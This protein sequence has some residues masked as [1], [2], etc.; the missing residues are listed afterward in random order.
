MSNDALK[1]EGYTVPKREWRK[2]WKALKQLVETPEDTTQVFIIM[3]AL[4]GDAFWKEF[5]RFKATEFGKHVLSEK[6]DLFDTLTNRD[7]LSSLPAGSFG[8]T[9]YDF[10]QREGIS[11]EGLVEASDGHYE[12][13]TSEDMLRYARRS[14]ESHD[15]WHILS[16]YG[17]DG[18][19][20]AC[21]VSFSYAQTKS[22]GF[23]AIAAMGAYKFK[24][25]FPDAPIWR[26]VW[27]AYRIGKK[28]AWLPGVEW[29]KLMDLPLEEVR[30][31]LGIT[32]PNLYQ[33]QN[34]VIAGTRP[35]VLAA[36]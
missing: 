32:A 20:E 22:L 24:Q 3:R 16:G 12:E 9:Y 21:V 19:G 28:A 30:E 13:F 17:R 11:P 14:R 35:E 5:Q 4:A 26:A 1:S 15:L 10:C 34:H 29:E 27:Q 33:A 6:I 2:A 18:F 23:G 36:Q 25:D 8:R 31:K 7:Y